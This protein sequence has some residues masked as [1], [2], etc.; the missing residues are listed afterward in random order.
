MDFVKDY[1]SQ[2]LDSRNWSFESHRQLFLEYAPILILL[3]ITLIVGKWLG[4]KFRMA[5]SDFYKKRGVSNKW[6]KFLARNNHKRFIDSW[7]SYFSDPVNKKFFWVSFTIGV[8]LMLLAAK[9]VAFNANTPGKILYDPF[10]ALLP[11]KNWS[12]LIFFIE[13]LAIIAMFF[14]VIDRPAYFI[15]CL[16]GVVVLQLVR[17]LFIVFIPLSPP[18]DMIFLVDPFTQFFFG[19]NI[20]VSNDLFFSGHVS[21]LVIFFFMVQNKYLKYYLLFASITVGLLLVW[22]HV[23]YTYD[24]LFA[25]FASYGVYKFVVEKNWSEVFVQKIRT[26]T[27]MRQ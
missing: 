19:E 15:R 18:S 14:H 26:Q 16:A 17:C 7:K 5:W 21:L 2:F 22:Q 10:M 23:H 3:I 25:P 4:G 9:F 13:Y 8:V 24:V 27:E 6:S 12:K 11:V 1:F 20:H